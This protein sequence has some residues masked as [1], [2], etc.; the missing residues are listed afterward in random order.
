LYEILSE[1]V[2]ICQPVD[3]TQAVDCLISAYFVFNI[4]Y[5]KRAHGSLVFLQHT[6][7]GHDDGV[8]VSKKVV[9]LR[10]RLQ[11]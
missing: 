2:V 11:L 7:K 6:M 9:A 1:D 3:I 5:E 8:A 10:R 4:T